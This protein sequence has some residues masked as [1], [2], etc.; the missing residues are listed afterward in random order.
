MSDVKGPEPQRPPFWS[1]LWSWARA[2]SRRMVAEMAGTEDHEPLA[3]Q[4]VAVR[5][6]EVRRW[7]V[8]KTPGQPPAELV[9]LALSGGGIRSATFSLGLLQA[10]AKE[11]KLGR[12]DILSTVSGGSYIGCFLRGLFLP[13]ECRGIDKPPSAERPIQLSGE[14]IEDQAAF[15]QRALK[16]NAGRR[17]IEGPG[18]RKVCNPLWWLREH[19]RY[20]APNGPTDFGL[21]I[22][23]LSRNWIAMIYVFAIGISLPLAASAALGGALTQWTGG[24]VY[25][26]ISHA[27]PAAAPQSPHAPPAPISSFEAHV[28]CPD[29]RSCRFEMNARAGV[30]A[31]T[32]SGTS[33]S[34]CSHVGQWLSPYILFAVIPLILSLAI[35]TA[36]WLTV[37]MSTNERDV[38]NQRRSFFLVVA[39]MVGA[40]AAVPLVIVVVALLKV[41]LALPAARMFPTIGI[42]GLASAGAGLLL[43]VLELAIGLLAYFAVNRRL[44]DHAVRDGDIA[45]GQDE[46]AVRPH[47]R[48]AWALLMVAIVAAI[49]AWALSPLVA[50][51]L[52]LQHNWNRLRGAWLLIF[53]SILALGSAIALGWRCLMVRK[54]IRDQGTFSHSQKELLT[55]ELR[56]DLTSLQATSNLWMVILLAVGTIET[57]GGLLRR[58]FWEPHDHLLQGL[59]SGIL[60]PA[61]AFLLKKLPDW[62]GGGG[63]KGGAWA[64][65][66]RFMSTIAL[67]V[68]IALYAA[69]AVV[70]DA[71]IHAVLWNGSSWS[72][73]PDWPTFGLVA[74]I[75][76]LLVCLTGLCPGFLNLSSWHNLYASRLT[77]AYLGASN[78]D[79]LLSIADPHSRDV[80]IKDNHVGDYIQPDIYGRLVLPAPLHVIN[81]T[82]NRTV[83]PTSQIVA[84]DRKGERLSIEPHGI[85]YRGADKDEILPWSEMGSRKTKRNPTAQSLSLGQWCAISGAA[86]PPGLRSSHVF[87]QCAAGLLVVGTATW[88]PVRAA[89]PQDLLGVVPVLAFDTAS[90]LHVPLQ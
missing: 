25:S 87:C 55:A 15:A 30:A 83:D 43:I 61:I 29:S 68:G 47:R 90:H 72:S 69:V 59:T 41:W 1:R 63:K 38:R 5:Q 19:S 37:Q 89:R 3:A 51:A 20:L 2:R 21:A 35:G 57:L 53:A 73:M 13:E 27:L 70:V 26:A 12:I 86:D 40:A 9:G 16:S 7:W 8:A 77:R 36:H 32:C 85:G 56:G 31:S 62:F 46:S 45:A 14:T 42:G 4:N 58:W 44:A 6:G 10:L 49:L 74:L 23:Y 71:I 24:D 65:V 54:K 88:A 80:T 64:L 82:L 39:G 22:A 75:L 84:R 33:T 52:G 48:R 67:A 18:G 81:I 17:T 28:A 66:G 60:V 11:G 50:D 78:I 79:R 76:T 34:S